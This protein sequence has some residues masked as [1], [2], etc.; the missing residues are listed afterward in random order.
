[1]VPDQP[2]I[3]FLH[4]WETIWSMIKAPIQ[5][6]S[7]MAWVTGIVL[8]TMHRVRLQWRRNFRE[9]FYQGIIHPPR[10]GCIERKNN[11]LFDLAAAATT[12]P[13]FWTF[14]A[15]IFSQGNYSD[16]WAFVI[17]G[18][19]TSVMMIRM[20]QARLNHADCETQLLGENASWPRISPHWSPQQSAFR[21]LPR[22][23]RL[24]R[25]HP[26]GWRGWRGAV[27]EAPPPVGHP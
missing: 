8:G 12:L 6:L 20:I 15:Y 24:P 4:I 11:A 27:Q 17:V 1:L 26:R 13:L 7:A 25:P 23:L 14:I 18:V 10:W 2:V 5:A 21:A 3:Q 16:A 19:P 9:P 22:L